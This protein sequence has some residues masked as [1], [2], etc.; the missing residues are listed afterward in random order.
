[1]AMILQYSQRLSSVKLEKWQIG[2]LCSAPFVIGLGSI[3]AKK[4][5][6]GKM[7]GKKME[8]AESHTPAQ[9]LALSKEA[10]VLK[11]EGNNCYRSERYEDAVLCYD[12]AIEK[13]PKDQSI[14]M[15]MLLHNRAAAYEMLKNWDKVM[16]DCTE[17]LEYS[18]RYFKSYA[19]RA[20]AYEA[21]NQLK[22][23]LDDIT[24]CCILEMFQN[25][26]SIV[27]AD[28]ILKLTGRE[29]ADAEIANRPPIV[30]SLFVV[31]SYMR[32]FIDDPLQTISVQALAK[33]PSPN[34]FVRAHW[35]FRGGAFTEIIPGCTEEIE[36]SLNES[37]YKL[38][39]LLM[40]GTFHML[41]NSFVESK[42]DFGAI[43]DDPN[44]D[45]PFR[46]Y[47]YIRRATV[48]TLLNER[49]AAIADFD[50][51]EEIQSANPDVY[52][53]RALVLMPQD[54]TE[55]ELAQ[56]EMA[57]ALAPN[58]GFAVIKKCYVDYRATLLTGGNEKRKEDAMR[59]FQE[60]IVKFPQCVESYSLMAQVLVDQQ[61][62]ANANKKYEEALKLEPS[63]S[64]VMVQHALMVLQWRGDKEMATELLNQAIV[65]NPQCQQ[66]YETLGT[67]EVQRV[68]LKAAVEQFDKAI[69]CCSSYE[70]LVHA[71]ALRNAAQAQINV[72]DKLSIDIEGMNELVQQRRPRPTPY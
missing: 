52:L 19:R 62:F 3:A 17:S 28:Q 55:V 5:F 12:K 30:P 40:R 50:A 10:I 64:S 44:A 14:D 39:A 2:V 72:T 31:N 68:H 42:R 13:C 41:S 48:H 7:K 11:T 23:S 70:D 66:A 33:T 6:G 53:Q 54:H 22:A 25:K 21:R 32:T 8:A 61:D 58:N 27:F 51:A 26:H 69:G 29:D 15:S 18:P 37:P 43:I 34:G 38:E 4:L 35:A 1:M 9:K 56:Y 71:F 59:R 57:V 46:A 47:A 24:A 63:N 45:D 36:E 65:V 60:A 20:R 49:E 16:Q 67:I